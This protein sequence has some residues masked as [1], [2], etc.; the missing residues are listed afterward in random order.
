M[1]GMSTRT[2]VSSDMLSPLITANQK[3]AYASGTV[4][5][6]T[7]TAAAITLGTTSPTI[8]LDQTGTYK[9]DFRARFENVGATFAAS[10]LLTLKARVTS[11]TPAD[12]ANSTVLLNTPVI[13]ALTST[14]CVLTGSVIYN[15]TAGDVISLFTL[16]DTVPSAGSVTVPE[17]SIVAYRLQ[18]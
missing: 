9:I 15:A 18:Q 2:G 10:R 13:T 5:T 7:N 8:T 12:I 17:A 14:L 1:T 16:L 4:Y 3:S 6:L 11:G